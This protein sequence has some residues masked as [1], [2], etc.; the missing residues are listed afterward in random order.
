MRVISAYLLVRSRCS[1]WQLLLLLYIVVEVGAW[2]EDFH[3]SAGS[4]RR[5]LFSFIR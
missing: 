5:K 4:A 3:C 2:L 1:V